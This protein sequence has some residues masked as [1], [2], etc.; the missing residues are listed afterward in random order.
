MVLPSFG[1]GETLNFVKDLDD[2]VHVGARSELPSTDIR[3]GREPPALG[4]FLW[5]A[6]E[7]F[8]TV[9]GLTGPRSRSRGWQRSRSHSRDR[10]I[11]EDRH[12]SRSRSRERRSGRSRPGPRPHGSRSP[13]RDEGFIGSA[14]HRRRNG[15][16]SLPESDVVVVIEE[17]SLP[18][19]KR[20][21]QRRS[22]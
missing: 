6:E 12:T 5:P 9:F 20:T 17:H 14:L 18:P 16:A 11:R 22:S 3:A 15:S 10:A 13:P 19:R 7:R 1:F 21:I 4:A 8:P 2:V